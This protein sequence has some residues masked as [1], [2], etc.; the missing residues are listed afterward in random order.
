MNPQQ[1]A[2]VSSAPERPRVRWEGR[3]ENGG[4]SPALAIPLSEETCPCR[5]LS[6]PEMWASLR[7]HSAGLM[8]LATSA[9]ALFTVTVYFLESAG[10]W[11]LL[12]PILGLAGWIWRW[13]GAVSGVLLLACWFSYFPI[14]SP[15]KRTPVVPLE[16][17]LEIDLI[18]AV[19]AVVVYASCHWRYVS[20]MQEVAIQPQAREG[21]VVRW[22]RPA[23]IVPPGEWFRC[24]R[25][26]VLGVAAAW[27]LWLTAES[28][29][30]MPGYDP[31]VAWNLDRSSLTA[32][33]LPGWLS[34]L[35]VLTAVVAGVV[36]VSYC[37][38][39]LLR[40]RR[41]NR[42]EAAMLL[43]EQAWE[44]LHRE[45]RR[46]AAFQGRV[47]RLKRESLTPEATE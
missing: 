31:P 29:I 28:V 41:L 27:L 7:T 36:L 12:F 38:L 8:Y 1:Q 14:G 17:T 13:G 45:W 37:L 20:L 30:L 40:Y 16:S 24:L 5:P 44:Q 42:D 9:A 39:W 23:E 6:T 10:E 33:A 15:I 3:A 32:E 2:A 18:F 22:R 25:Q 11:S 19:L 21:E 4:Q 47:S 43:Q 46:A 26:A 34:R 35:M